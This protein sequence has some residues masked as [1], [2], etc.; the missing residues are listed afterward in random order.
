MRGEMRGGDDDRHAPGDML[1]HG[2]H[3]EVALVIGQHELLG[4]IGEDA[5]AMRA[6]IDH[7]IDGALLSGKV[8]PALRIEDGG[9]NREDALIGP[10]GGRGR[11]R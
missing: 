9:S 1:Q 4:E 2:A 8:Q 3:D 11:H 10:G 6:G 5:Q 7:A